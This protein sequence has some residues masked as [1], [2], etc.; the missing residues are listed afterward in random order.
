VF[1]V[2]VF[3]L[4]FQAQYCFQR[5]ILIVSFVSI[6]RIGDL[7]RHRQKMDRIHARVNVMSIKSVLLKVVLR[8]R[9]LKHYRAVQQIRALAEDYVR[10]NKSD[11]NNGGHG[12]GSGSGMGVGQSSTSAPIAR[13]SHSAHSSIS[14]NQTAGRKSPKKRVRIHTGDSEEDDGVSGVGF[15]S[16]TLEGPQCPRVSNIQFEKTAI[17]E[18]ESIDPEKAGSMIRSL[19]AQWRCK[20]LAL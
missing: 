5:V 2:S 12:G 9:F 11:D 14:T 10:E 8:Q 18:E 13:I 20:Y 7:L 3:C 19:R 6:Y 16:S 1:I 4:D 15:E 17:E